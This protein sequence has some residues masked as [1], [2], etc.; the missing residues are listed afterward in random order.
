MCVLQA[1]NGYIDG[2]RSVP[3][4]IY[5]W[6]PKYKD[7]RALMAESDVYIYPLQSR[8][9]FYECAK[10]TGALFKHRVIFTKDGRITIFYI[11]NAKTVNQ[12]QIQ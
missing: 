5:V 2:S 10:L 3:L 12:I 9:V 4:I 11:F 1:N 8:S 6:Y 7:V